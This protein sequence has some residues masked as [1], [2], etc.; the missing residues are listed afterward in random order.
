MA[1]FT[2]ITE[3]ALS[4]AL[5]KLGALGIKP[6]IKAIRNELGVGS[7]STIIKMKKEIAK[8]SSELEKNLLLLKIKMLSSEVERLKNYINEQK[9]TSKN[10][11]NLVENN[12]NSHSINNSNSNSNSNSKTKNSVK[13]ESNL[14]N[15]LRSSHENTERSFRKNKKKKRKK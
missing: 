6:T 4:N 2:K 10:T 8:K 7:Y 3:F 13:I 5:K 1:R 12:S 14:N 9:Y 11:E 15:I